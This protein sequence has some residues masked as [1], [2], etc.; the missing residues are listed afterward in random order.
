MPPST[1]LPFGGSNHLDAWR[2]MNF[3]CPRTTAVNAASF[4]G[5]VRPAT[6][7]SSAFFGL[8]CSC[9][10]TIASRTGL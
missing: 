10:S 4:L 2:R 6:I 7:A 1:Q 8:S 3:L 5:S 9:T